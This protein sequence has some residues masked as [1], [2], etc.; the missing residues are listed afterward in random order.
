[1]TAGFSLVGDAEASASSG[2]RFGATE[3]GPD[4]SGER[5]MGQASAW[6]SAS[7][8]QERQKLWPQQ[9]ASTGRWKLPRQIGQSLLD[10]SSSINF[11]SIMF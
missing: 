1:V 11:S 5:H 2:A 9:E 7:S 8:R 3:K 4:S 6:R 10:M